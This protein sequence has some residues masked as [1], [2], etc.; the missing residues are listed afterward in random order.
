MIQLCRIHSV[1][2]RNSR[3][4]L[5]FPALT[6]C[7]EKVNLNHHAEICIPPMYFPS[8]MYM[9]L[10]WQLETF[11]DHSLSISHFSIFSSSTLYLVYIINM[12]T[13]SYQ[14]S[15]LDPLK[16]TTLTQGVKRGGGGAFQGELPEVG[17][18]VYS[19]KLLQFTQSCLLLPTF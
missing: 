12:Y 16:T 5:Y 19:K 13:C 2:W 4:E 6:F 9:C 7:N 18:P 1:S 17:V 15:K 3:V 14:Y 10:H 8:H 11:E